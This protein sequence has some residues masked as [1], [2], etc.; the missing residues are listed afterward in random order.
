MIP[1][2]RQR[3]NEQFSNDKYERFLALVERRTF[4]PPK[5]RHSETPLFLPRAL[6]REMA[7]AGRELVLQLMRNPLYLAESERAIPE[8]FRVQ[9]D[10]GVPLFLQVDFGLDRYLRPKLVEIQGFPSLYAYQPVL[11]DCYREIYRLEQPFYPD[12]LNHETYRDLV[13]RAI[14]ADTNPKE[15]ILL[16]IDPWN[17]KTRG[18]F[19]LTQKL[20]GVR[21]VDIR[22]VRQSGRELYYEYDGRRIG[23]RRIY[24][25]AI[26]DELQRRG[27]PLR[28]DWTGDLDVEWAGHPNWFFRISKFS[29]PYLR[30]ET[31][32]ETYLVRDKRSVEDPENWV[33]KP[34]FSF[35]GMGVVVGPS[36]EQIASAD[37]DG[38]ILQ[39]RIDFAAPIATP[40]G[41]TKCEIR[42]MYLWLE[43][44]PTVVNIVVRTGRG[45]QMGVDFNTGLE[46]VGAS[47][48]FLS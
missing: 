11:A 18:D 29:L 26:V 27:I 31:V 45:A 37:P 5:F 12:G 47:A 3:F 28:F 2:L 14:L 17:Q 32:P 38:Y 16:E 43:D 4:T 13:C 7:H 46:W 23:I 41:P 36:G 24:N 21:T 19:V 1:S 25:R 30:H 8:A 44:A 33:L 10:E 39:R 15:T 34:L 20:C 9:G 48:A 35:A 22:D 40:F 42:M 6:A